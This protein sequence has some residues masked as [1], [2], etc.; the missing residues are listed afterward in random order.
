MKI[1]NKRVR[2]DKLTALNYKH[3]EEAS[4][5]LP[6]LKARSLGTFKPKLVG[7]VRPPKPVAGGTE[8]TKLCVDCGRHFDAGVFDRHLQICEKVF[9]GKRDVFDSAKYRT[10]KKYAR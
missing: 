5:K 9:R 8:N 6:E 7:L 4:R 10:Q 2:D 3:K 1:E